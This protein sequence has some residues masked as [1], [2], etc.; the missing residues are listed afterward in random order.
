M[1]VQQG[2]SIAVCPGVSG[3]GLQGV[4]SPILHLVQPEPRRLVRL[5]YWGSSCKPQYVSEDK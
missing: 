3:K 5:T 2:Q 4:G 1:Q